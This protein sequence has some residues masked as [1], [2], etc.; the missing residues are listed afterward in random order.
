[1]RQNPSATGVIVTIG[2]LFFAAWAFKRLQ[3]KM[4]ALQDAQLLAV[5]KTTTVPK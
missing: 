3:A 1:M 4:K 2:G 5:A